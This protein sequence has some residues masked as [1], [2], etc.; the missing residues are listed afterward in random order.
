MAKP[1]RDLRLLDCSSSSTVV[2]DPTAFLEGWKQQIQEKHSIPVHQQRLTFAS[3]HSLVPE[4]S[5]FS[6]NYLCPDQSVQGPP[7]GDFVKCLQSWQAILRSENHNIARL[8]KPEV[9]T[10]SDKL[11][12][13][14]KCKA[15]EE[16]RDLGIPCKV[17]YLSFDKWILALQ[18]RT[19]QGGTQNCKEVSKIC[20][21]IDKDFQRKE[22]EV[23]LYGRLTGSTNPFHFSYHFNGRHLAAQLSMLEQTALYRQGQK[24]RH[25][26]GRSPTT[27]DKVAE[28]ISATPFV[29][30]EGISS[31]SEQCLHQDYYIPCSK[32]HELTAIISKNSSQLRC[33]V[34][35]VITIPPDAPWNG[36]P[37]L[38]QPIN[39]LTGKTLLAPDARILKVDSKP[40]RVPSTRF[41]RV[42]RKE[43]D[44]AQHLPSEHLTESHLFGLKWLKHDKKKISV[45][46]NIKQN[47][48]GLQIISASHEFTSCLPHPDSLGTS[49]LT[50]LHEKSSKSDVSLEKVSKKKKRKKGKPNLKR[51]NCVTLGDVDMGNAQGFTSAG[52]ILP[53][54]T[55]VPKSSPSLAGESLHSA[56]STHFELNAN[57][58]NNHDAEN[59]ETKSFTSSYL[60]AKTPD[61]SSTLK[62]APEAILTK[63]VNTTDSLNFVNCISDTEQEKFMCSGV[64]NSMHLG[65]NVTLDWPFEESVNQESGNGDRN[66][67]VPVGFVNVTEVA[68]VLE[69]DSCCQVI[70]HPL[71]TCNDQASLQLVMDANVDSFGG[72]NVCGGKNSQCSAHSHNDSETIEKTVLD[73]YGIECRTCSPSTNLNSGL[74]KESLMCGCGSSG[75]D[76]NCSWACRGRD[77]QCNNEVEKFNNI[78]AVDDDGKIKN[79][80]E[81]IRSREAQTD[82]C[83]NKRPS[84]IPAHE[85]VGSNRVSE[86]TSDAGSPTRGGS[87]YSGG[88]KEKSNRISGKVPKSL[89]DVSRP[90]TNAPSAI[91]QIE[92]LVIKSLTAGSTTS[93]QS[94]WE[95]SNSGC[96]QEA[97][98]LREPYDCQ[99]VGKSQDQTGHSNVPGK[100][101]MH[102]NL[103]QCQSR[104]NKK[105]L[106]LLSLHPNEKHNMGH[107]P[108][109]GAATEKGVQARK[110]EPPA[111]IDRT[112]VS[113]KGDFSTQRNS[114][115]SK[116]LNAGGEYLQCIP[117]CKPQVR[118]ISQAEQ[119]RTSSAPP[120]T[121]EHGYASHIF[122]EIFSSV[123]CGG[124]DRVPLNQT[125]M[126]RTSSLVDQ[127]TLQ[128]K[129]HGKHM[130]SVGQIVEDPIV[131]GQGSFHSS[132]WKGRKTTDSEKGVSAGRNSVQDNSCSQSQVPAA[133]LANGV[134]VQLETET[135]N[136]NHVEHCTSKE[137]GNICG[138]SFNYLPGNSNAASS[139]H[140]ELQKTS[141]V[142]KAIHASYEC[143]MVS[144][145]IV[146]TFGNPIAEF[147]KFLH[148][149]APVILPVYDKQQCSNT[150]WT[151]LNRNLICR[152]QLANVPLNNIWQWYEEP[153]NYGLEV[154]AE[155]LQH[156]KKL[157]M[158]GN[159]FGAY[160]VPFLSGMQLFGFSPSQSHGKGAQKGSLKLKKNTRTERVELFPQFGNLPILAALLPKP[161][162]D[163]SAASLHGS[164]ACNML[165]EDFK[166]DDLDLLFEFF[167]SEQPQQRRP[168][169]AKMEELSRV[170]ANLSSQLSGETHILDSLKLGDLHPVSWF[171][172]SWY[173]IYR[174]PEGPLRAAFLTYHS[175]GHFVDGSTTSNTLDGGI[176]SNIVAPVVGLQSY[177]S[178]SECWFDLGKQYENLPVERET[179]NPSEVLQNRLRTLE[180]TAAL[181]SRG[182][183]KQGTAVLTN[184][185]SDYEFF[186]SRQR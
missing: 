181:M 115:H 168:M 86:N 66:W 101:T 54:A 103:A 172:V 42:S 84:H 37:S 17:Y 147:E 171:A 91:S 71:G 176:S 170:G 146:H 127:V 156:S 79:S 57:D 12:P 80:T 87:I 85:M 139:N 110:G 48:G 116:S 52:S 140:G 131:A 136:N 96:T 182:L 21:Q 65:K 186:L 98:N 10:D 15:A 33:I 169:F 44:E 40:L 19:S 32:D 123:G 130:M 24:I 59:D 106:H 94:H 153:G 104:Q 112:S 166:L 77:S 49:G 3:N 50:K 89:L 22:F 149:A 109:C 16:F 18:S 56:M 20:I 1:A 151:K 25:C 62:S 122:R 58:R 68:G 34:L 14:L 163:S 46:A 36:L 81:V 75:G 133:T 2:L 141:P 177:N 90:Q 174:I 185:H 99:K 143:Q 173:P 4:I 11:P 135:S 134:T 27:V 102:I 150:S 47:Q 114:N 23:D 137:N 117:H 124:Q 160:F 121:H 64:R 132:R 7:V 72:Q 113:Q 118:S 6:W 158:Y 95:N 83:Y 125:L 154:K 145:N 161:I 167:E 39:G 69:S 184:K 179:S 155:D 76:D 73:F 144:E 165:P 82:L 61:V 178:R 67:S 41:H 138:T 53:E 5:L 164:C 29:L 148:A 30:A 152:C 111:Y 129:Q 180:E 45:G 28:T 120:R 159:S 100:Q 88:G 126:S 74:G 119:P 55:V 13:D 142:L 128:T 162:S 70:S 63:V 108:A 51:S 107:R 43:A 26:F 35:T 38:L 175:L 9:L 60:K 8:L 157:E 97:Q 78:K 31:W 92:P 93:E 183:T 105:P